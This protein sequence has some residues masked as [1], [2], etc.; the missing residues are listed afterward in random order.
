[1][2]VSVQKQLSI[3]PDKGLGSKLDASTT[4]T[5]P[6]KSIAITRQVL[7]HNNLAHN[8]L[9]VESEKICSFSGV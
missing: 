2:K 7:H 8:V 4:P 5:L 1:M 3:Y 9:A 6:T